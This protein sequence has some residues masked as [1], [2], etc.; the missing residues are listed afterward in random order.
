MAIVT[1]HAPRPQHAL[2]VTIVSRSANVVHDFIAAIL[3]NGGPNFA[4]EGIQHLIPRSTLPLALSTLA[5]TFEGIEDAFGVV[6]L[7][8]GGGTLGTAAPAAP[9][10]IGIALEFFDPARLFI[11]VGQ[12]PTGRLA[13]EADGGN[14]FIV[15][16]DFARP[17]LRI[18]FDPIAPAFRW[19]TRCQV[20]HSHLLP[21]GRNVLL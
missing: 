6:D 8:D 12:Q 14:N 11:H 19:R 16:L 21:T 17:C 18:I 3:N 4:G 2:H 1:I 20:T 9:W 15:F 5:C 13:V 7:V 10:V